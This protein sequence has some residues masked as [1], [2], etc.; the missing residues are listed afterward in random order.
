MRTTRDP[1][2]SPPVGHASD[3][4]VTLVTGIADRLRYEILGGRIAPGAK[5]RADDLKSKFDV[6]LTPIR[7]ALMRLSS[8]GLVIAED[9]RG[10][11]VAPMSLQNLREVTELRVALERLALRLSIEAGDLEWEANVVAAA[12]RL[13]A[14]TS[15][16]QERV[17]TINEQWEHWHRQ[18][19]FALIAACNMPLLISFCKT[20]HDLCDRY[21]RIYLP[22]I[23]PVDRL[24]DHNSIAE[25]ACKRDAALAVKLMTAHIRRTEA[26]IVAGIKSMPLHA[27]S[28]SPAPASKRPAGRRKGA[29]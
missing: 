3:G 8:E 11:R 10:F 24:K 16:K 2:M 13:A 19:H 25:A 9:Q 1:M 7:E 27:P 14:L 22:I 15:R 23:R 5:I 12:H 28:A 4:T 20:V 6:S 21:R 29:E 26:V 17:P 18:F